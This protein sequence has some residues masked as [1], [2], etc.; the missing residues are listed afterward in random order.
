MVAGETTTA[1]DPTVVSYDGGTPFGGRRAARR[2]LDILGRR[3]G[4][5][6]RRPRRLGG[7][8][9]DV[10]QGRRRRTGSTASPTT[11]PATASSGTTAGSSAGAVPA[12]SGLAFTRSTTAVSGTNTSGTAVSGV[13][14]S[15]AATPPPST[16]RSRAPRPGVLLGGAG[17]QQGYR[18]LGIG[19]YGSHNGSGWGVF[20]TSELRD[21]RIGARP[22]RRVARATGG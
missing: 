4:Q 18:R 22:A 20:G 14:D 7:G 19:V 12:C 3:R 21:R 1:E 13:S 17:R 16:A 2:R 11:A 8:G 9:L 15:T 10:R 6:P 5:L